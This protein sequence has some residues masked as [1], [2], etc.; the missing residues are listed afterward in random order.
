[1][2]MF[3]RFERGVLM[4]P[5]EPILAGVGLVTNVV[6]GIQKKSAAEKAADLQQQAANA[7]AADIKKTAADVNPTLLAAAN[8][9]AT[10]ATTAA[11]AAATG[12]TT[13]ADKA[14]SGVTD[15]ALQ[16][17]AKLDPYAAAGADAAATLRAGLAEG[18]DFNKTP[19]L[20]DLQMDPG[21]AFRVQ[22]GQKALE[23][24]RA[25]SGTYGSGALLKDLTNYS[26][27]AA[28]QEYQNA[29]DRYQ[30]STQSRYAR[31]FGEQGVGLTAATTQ[32]N[33]LGSAARYAGDTGVQAAEYGGGLRYD[34]S[35]YA[36]NLNYGAATKT[37]D[38]T[39]DA[40]RTAADYTTGGAAARAAGIVG[41]TNAMWNGINSGV[42]SA[43][44]ALATRNPATTH[45]RPG[46]GPAGPPPPGTGGQY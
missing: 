41:G 18:G 29:F 31:L 7:A 38:N 45:S 34:A 25:A 28:S 20:A 40:A 17:N 16:A 15:A 35:R 2:S 19:T 12:A 6:G 33:N 24:S 27:G 13:A 5:L 22:E 37:A 8:A 23:R 43:A 42:N 10:G 1:M 36:G 32:G 4:N 26:Q 44:T 46:Y 14:A 39:I 11:D 30:Q 21:Y 3:N 9:G